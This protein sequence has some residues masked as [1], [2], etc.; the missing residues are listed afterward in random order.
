MEAIWAATSPSSGRFSEV[1][2]RSTEDKLL[3]RYRKLR[4]RGEGY[5]EVRAGSRLS[6]AR[7]GLSRAARGDPPCRRTR[8][9]FAPPR[10]QLGVAR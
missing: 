2:I 5:L 4:E 1:E 3:E 8:I 10:R 7:V 9:D 6:L